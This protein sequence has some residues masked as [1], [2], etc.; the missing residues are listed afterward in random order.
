LTAVRRRHQA[1]RAGGAF[2]GA[3]LPDSKGLLARI[4][5]F[6]SDLKLGIVLA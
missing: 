5:R 4:F 6:R 2:H 3:I 1:D